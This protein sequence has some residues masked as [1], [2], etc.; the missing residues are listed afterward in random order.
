MAEAALT[1]TL[2]RALLATV[3]SLKGECLRLRLP[4]EQSASQWHRGHA[5]QIGYVPRSS[6]ARELFAPLA[7][8]DGGPAGA[9]E[10]QP[11]T[12]RGII[13]SE[14]RRA[15]AQQHDRRGQEPESAHQLSGVDAGLFAL[16]QLHAQLELA[17]RSSTVITQA[18]NGAAVMVEATSAYRGRDGPNFVF[19]YRVR[20]T[21]VGSVAVQVIGRSWS[22]RNADD[23]EHASVPR[24]SPGIVGQSPR[25]EPDGDAFEYASG[26]TLATA[27]GSVSGSLQMMS[28][29]EGG[30]P[31]DAEVGTFMCIAEGETK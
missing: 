9:A 11:A 10:L 8:P 18:E 19:Q 26:T 22:I 2:Y 16:K 14:F 5:K 29:A 25:L 27:G 4:V 13:R 12:V 7:L 28:L 30:V 20:L 15:L 3:R 1:V 24:G 21:N 6:A 23:S 17:R 31:F